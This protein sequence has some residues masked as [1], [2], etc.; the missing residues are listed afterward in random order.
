MKYAVDVYWE[1]AKSFEVEAASAAE[2]EKI[3]LD[4]CQQLNGLTDAERD[5]KMRSLGLGSCAD[6][7]EVR[8]V[9]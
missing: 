1:F 7:Y 4:K 2:A 5:A 3:V 6:S 8:V 9:E